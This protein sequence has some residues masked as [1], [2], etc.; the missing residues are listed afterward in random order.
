MFDVKEIRKLF[1]IYLHNENLTY[2]D[3]CATSLK[4]L[5]VLNKMEEYYREYGV[6]IHRGVYKL[7]Y[8]ATL[9]YDE[10]RE[11]VASFLN[12]KFDEVI[13]VRNASEALNYCCLTYGEQYLNSG[14]EVITSELDHH[15]CFL[16]WLKLCER[17]NAFLK[18]IPLNSDGRITVESFLAVLTE[19]TKV[20]ALNMYS[21]VMGYR[22]PIE[23]IIKICHERGII[24]IVDAAQAVPHERIDVKALDCDFLCFSGHKM[25]G[26]TGIGVLYAKKSILKKLQPL[27]YGGD[28][29]NEVTKDSVELKEI[30]FCFETGTPAIS[31]VIGLG[32]AID[33]ILEIGYDNIHNHTMELYNYT[34]DRLKNIEGITIYN[35]NPE[36]PIISFNIDG[37]HPHDAATIFDENNIC[38]RA[39]H[40]C[41]QLLTKWLNV[42]GTLRGS[43]YIYNDFN[44]CD[45]FVNTVKNCVEFF[46][47]INGE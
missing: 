14:D 25:M 5:R 3:T 23:E 6:N 35:K 24:C 20:V 45:K 46:K 42:I 26:P 1:P 36:L 41:A 39:G 44:D 27:F 29:N 19:R 18:Y 13:F 10:A 47:K 7:S 32:E 17:K 8:D 11:K 4:P 21:N 2:L 12:C 9:K 22:S 43:F 28:M 30:P 38:L 37:V 33:M 40:H 16:P 34:M 31:E 15:S